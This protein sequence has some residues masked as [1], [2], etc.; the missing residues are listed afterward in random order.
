MRYVL[1]SSAVIALLS[2]E[3]GAEKVAGLL[4]IS[5]ISSVNFSEVVGFFARR[6]L[7]RSDVENYLPAQ[8]LEVVPVDRK[9]AFEAGMMLQLL[10]QYGLSLGDRI[11]LALARQRSAPVLTADRMWMKVAADL[12]VTVELIR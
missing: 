2:R 8:A 9:T 5:L 11:C 3:P 4:D 10:S 6:G 12:G 7:T 1:D